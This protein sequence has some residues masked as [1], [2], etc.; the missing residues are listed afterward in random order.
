MYSSA[1]PIINWNSL[2]PHCLFFLAERNILLACL[3]DYL[4]QIFVPPS[5]AAASKYT[6]SYNKKTLWQETEHQLISKIWSWMQSVVRM[7]VSLYLLQASNRSDQVLSRN[8]ADSPWWLVPNFAFLFTF[9]PDAVSL[10]LPHVLSQERF[11]I[12]I[13]PQPIPHRI[14]PAGKGP[15]EQES[16]SWA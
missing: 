8:E 14:S 13:C 5:C 1:I 2:G 4:L 6:L 3:A 16:P 11:H 12:I 7:A 15:P 9:L 10:L